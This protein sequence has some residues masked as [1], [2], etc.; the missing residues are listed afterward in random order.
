[1]HTFRFV[2]LLLSL[3]VTAPAL[4][5][6]PSAASSPGTGVVLGCS[7]SD[8][9]TLSDETG[10]LREFVQLGAQVELSIGDQVFFIR[11]TTPNGQVVV[12]N[13]RKK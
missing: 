10:S 8:V 4:A 3:A 13:I 7:S 6:P 12:N 11:I 1:M 9:C 5:T 2:L